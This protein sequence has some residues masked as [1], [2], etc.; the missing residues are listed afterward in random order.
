MKVRTWMTKDPVTIGPNE[1]LEVAEGKMHRGRF[2]RL[3]VVDERGQL[4]GIITSR[5]LAE[6]HGYLPVTRVDAAIVERPITIGP[7]AP[8]EAA[9]ALLLQHKIGGLP[10]VASNGQLL[11]IITETD[12]LRGLLQG[13]SGG[14]AVSGRIDFQFT[15]PEQ[16]FAGAVALIE[17]AG[18]TILGLGTLRAED[19]GGTRTFYLRVLGRDI[20]ALAEALRRNGYAVGAVH[21]ATA[22]WATC[23]APRG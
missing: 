6:H 15:D 23:G 21:A 17:A 9:A 8:I 1:T 4:L 5:D 10:V 16:T 13:L 11:G 7:D 18:G 2:R 22:T 3:L 12:L 19:E 20:E 14:E